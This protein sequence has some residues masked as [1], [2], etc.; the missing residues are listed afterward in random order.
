MTRKVTKKMDAVPKSL[1]AA[2]ASRQ[3]PDRHMKPMRFRFSNSLSSVAAPAKMKQIF[4]SSE[5]CSETPK[6][7]IQFRAP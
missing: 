3:K 4:V 1:M 5:G 6:R 2:S 7:E